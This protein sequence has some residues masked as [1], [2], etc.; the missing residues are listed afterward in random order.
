LPAVRRASYH[1]LRVP[2]VAHTNCAP[3][4]NDRYDFSDEAIPYGAAMF[5]RL[6][7]RTLVP[8]LGAT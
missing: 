3:V 7:E 1:I 5:G 6:V 8:E 2:T 4:H